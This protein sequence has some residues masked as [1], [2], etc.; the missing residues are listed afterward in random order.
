M[1]RSMTDSETEFRRVNRIQAEHMFR[2]MIL[3]GRKCY[4]ML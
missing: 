3:I 1:K 2:N 4:V